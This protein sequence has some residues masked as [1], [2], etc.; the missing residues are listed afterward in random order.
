MEKGPINL[1]RE[2]IESHYLSV[3]FPDF[4]FHESPDFP[5]SGVGRSV[6]VFHLSLVLSQII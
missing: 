3:E 6:F 1:E 5:L 2:K 4:F